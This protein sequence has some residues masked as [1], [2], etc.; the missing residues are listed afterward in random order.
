M[1]YKRLVAIGVRGKL[2]KDNL[3]YRTENLT[4]DIENE[5]KAI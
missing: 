1:K 4:E 3:R 2:L 5:P